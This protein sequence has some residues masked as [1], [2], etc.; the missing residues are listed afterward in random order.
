MEIIASMAKKLFRGIS[1]CS[2]LASILIISLTSQHISHPVFAASQGIVINEVLYDPEGTDTGYEWIELKNVGS[3]PVDLAGWKI[4]AAGTQ[5]KVQTLLPLFTIDAGRIVLIG[6]PYV[7]QAEINVPIL[8]FQNG[9]TES[10]AIRIVDNNGNIIDTVIYDSPNTNQLPDDHVTPAVS[11]ATDVQSGSSL[12]RKPSDDTDNS[13]DDFAE[14]NTPT[15]GVENIFKP[16]A[17]FSID[18]P[19]YVNQDT[20]LD[21]SNSHGN[22]AEIKSWEWTIKGPSGNIQLSSGEI[23]H[24][25][26]TEE[27]NYLISL[28]VKDENNQ[29]DTKELEIEVI[30]NP[31][32]KDIQTIASVKVLDNGTTATIKGQ[33]TAPFNTLFETESYIQDGTGG[34]R[35]KKP[36]DI[37]LMFG[38]TYMLDGEID[39][40]YGE[41]R[42]TISQSELAQD[43]VVI[44]PVKISLTQVTENMLGLLV[45][46]TGKIDKIE[47]RYYYLTQDSNTTKFYISSI[48]EIVIPITVKN[49][50]AEITGIISRYGTNPDGSARLRIMPR[51]EEDIRT[52]ANSQSLTNTGDAILFPMLLE[53]IVFAKKIIHRFLSTYR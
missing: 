23:I 11:L 51:F 27:G 6:E 4:E 41:K 40:V 19:V 22:N 20:V 15:P 8:A 39:T 49:K 33:L 48:S 46:A 45:T 50:Y 36:D 29:T 28:I 35:I 26:F 5:F 30:E 16:I 10:D 7:T 21:A 3:T 18:T 1:A 12:C 44:T 17:E 47:G 2:L 52:S 32:L 14:C 9:G 13:A 53:L 25:T 31:E 34:I 38:K 42:F 37:D 24:F 43:E